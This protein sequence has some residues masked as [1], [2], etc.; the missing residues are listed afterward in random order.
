VTSSGVC[1]VPSG[2]P[3]KRP[4]VPTLMRS[5]VPAVVNSMAAWPW[6]DTLIDGIR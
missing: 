4:T 6:P 2:S 5:L 1:I 3:D